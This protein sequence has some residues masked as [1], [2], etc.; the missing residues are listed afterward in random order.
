MCY[1]SPV[2]TGQ[3][4]VISAKCSWNVKE[5]DLSKSWSLV[6]KKRDECDKAI[7]GWY[8]FK[9]WFNFS[10]IKIRTDTHVL[11]SLSQGITNAAFFFSAISTHEKKKGT[12][13]EESDESEDDQETSPVPRTS[14][15]Q[16]VNGDPTLVDKS[17]W[18][19]ITYWLALTT[20]NG[21][22]ANPLVVHRA[23]LNCG[24]GVTAYQVKHV[25]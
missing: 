11:V 19:A 8:Q 23:L 24:V 18:P 20:P 14:S 13:N 10:L 6:C 21:A 5:K 22:P 3:C 2:I 17:L 12:I 9:S 25:G 7:S 1:M 4:S 16:L 15:Q